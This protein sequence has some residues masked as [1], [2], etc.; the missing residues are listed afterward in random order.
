MLFLVF[1]IDQIASCWLMEEA[2][3]RNT[4]DGH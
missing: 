1:V 3:K 2:N 4:T